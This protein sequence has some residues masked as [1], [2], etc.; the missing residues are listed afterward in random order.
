MSERME[1]ICFTAE[2]MRKW[3]FCRVYRDDSALTLHLCFSAVKKVE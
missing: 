2:N 3:R 1:D